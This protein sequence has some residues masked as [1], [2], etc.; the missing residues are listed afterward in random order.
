M[1]CMKSKFAETFPD[2]LEKLM[3]QKYP[4]LEKHV[5][6]LL[7]AKETFSDWPDWCYL[8]VSATNEI[9]TLGID[10]AFTRQYIANHLND[11][12]MISAMIPW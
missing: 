11:I 1:G 5:T 6:T 7:D 2:K 3:A 8:P 12:Y 10:N 9:L 4:D